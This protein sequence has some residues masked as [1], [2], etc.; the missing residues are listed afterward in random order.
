MKRTLIPLLFFSAGIAFTIACAAKPAETGRWPD[1]LNIFI[2]GSVVCTLALIVWRKTISSGKTKGDKKAASSVKELFQK[3]YECRDFA[4]Q[5]DKKSNELD[6][7]SLCEAIDDLLIN[8]INPFVE[9]RRVLIDYFGMSKGSGILLKTAF[10]E[11]QFNRV[12]SASS[13]HCL[14]EARIS[15]E[16]ALSAMDEVVDYVE[17]LD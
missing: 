10:A 8:Y 17:H 3:L 11:R 2:I 4:K 7:G 15:F 5:I 13:D 12:F 14:K 16:L 1:T 9:N 6:T